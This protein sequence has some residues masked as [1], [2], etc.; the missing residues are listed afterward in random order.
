MTGL[1]VA[2]FSSGAIAQIEEVVVT[3]RKR[4]ENLQEIPLSVTVLGAEAI[5]R[6]GIR[7]LTD[8]AR[9]T[10]GLVIDKGFTFQDV[11]PNIRGLPATRGRPPIGIV[12]DGIDVSSESILTAGGGPL[13]NLNLL[14]VERV[15][16]VKGPQS[17]L[18]GRVAFGGAIAYNSV[19]PGDVFEGSATAEVATDGRT[20]L[21]GGITI[22][23]NDRLSLRAHAAYSKFDG[24]YRSSV[25]G[26]LLGGWESKGAAL[27]ARLKV[28]ESS[29]LVARLAF[30]SDEADQRPAYYQGA[31]SGFLVDIPLPAAAVGQLVGNGMGTTALPATAQTRRFGELLPEGCLCRSLDPLTGKDFAGFRNE[32]FIAS[33]RGE[34][35]LGAMTL[36]TWTGYLQ[37]D[38]RSDEDVDYYGQPLRAVTLPIPGGQGELLASG[39]GTGQLGFIPDTRQLNQEIRLGNL[40]GNRFRWA[41]GGLYWYEDA[42]QDSDGIQSFGLGPNVSTW[43]NVRQAGAGGRLPARRSGRETT[44]YSAYG[45]VELDFATRFTVLA[46]ARIAR[47]KYE[48]LFGPSN[49][50]AG[51]GVAAPATV[52][53]VGSPT[54]ATAESDY[55]APRVG[56]NVRLSEDLM[57]YASAAKGI[58]PGGISQI[59]GNPNDGAYEPEELWNYE[60]GIKSTWLDRR[61]VLNA[62]YFHM[63]YSKKQTSTLQV[64]PLSVNPAG[65]IARTVNIGQAKVDGFEA[66]LT[67]ELVSGLTASLSYTYLRAR[68]TDFVTAQ[69]SANQIIVIGNCT[70][71]QFDTFRAC[72]SSN[73]GRRMEQV[74]PHSLLAG[75]LYERQLRGGWRFTGDVSVQYRDDRFL[76]DSNAWILPSYS[77]TDVRLGVGNDKLAITVFG[78][79]VF[80]DDTVKTAQTGADTAAGLPLRTAVFAYAP[81]P[82]QWG[83]RVGYRF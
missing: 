79:N 67:A 11:R 56:L 23:V 44:H 5:E 10:P 40:T 70:M 12:L 1:I 4:A 2:L 22:P 60:V 83:L 9:A 18:Y 43:L 75:L 20:D 54:T 38:G 82:A 52:I 39:N 28:G 61:L 16:V 66:D 76:N 42:V 26:Q 27:A 59:A 81:D 55:F 34:F 58:K 50:F 17:A 25:S 72:L 33:L 78:T 19:E 30:A 29:K 47:E 7:N 74:P 35:E 46:E 31:F 3:A 21:R 57:T 36:S 6:Y 64:V 51:N 53:A 24:F 49:G 69:T 45:L 77:T 62:A 8:L 37:A 41:V 14:D 73:T 71:Q 80:D 13:M 48:Y 32:P 15:E 65:V 63:D 68:Y